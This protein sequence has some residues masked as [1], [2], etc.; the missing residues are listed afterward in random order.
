ME[1]EFIFRLKH[2]RFEL[3]TYLNVKKEEFC[4]YSKYSR[5]DM[6]ETSIQ[7]IEIEIERL[8]LILN[9]YERFKQYAK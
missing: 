7:K 6:S 3:Q 2:Y 8:N 1:N 9:S 5:F 4:I